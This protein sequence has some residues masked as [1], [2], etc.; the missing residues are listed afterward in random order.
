M[1]KFAIIVKM[2]HFRS[3]DTPIIKLMIPVSY[4]QF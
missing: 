4:A 1:I 3:I 2:N